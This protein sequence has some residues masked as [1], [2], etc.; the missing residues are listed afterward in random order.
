MSKFQDLQKHAV[1]R[2]RKGDGDVPS[3]HHALSTIQEEVTEY[4]SQVWKKDK[5][6]DRFN[7][8]SELVQ[9]AARAQQAAEDLLPDE[10]NQLAR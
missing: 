7:M 10:L 4:Q 6:Q 1:A 8:V 9:I 2:Q 5:S 3:H